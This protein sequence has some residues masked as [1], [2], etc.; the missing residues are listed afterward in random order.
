MNGGKLRQ[1]LLAFGALGL[2]AT[3]FAAGKTGLGPVPHPFLHSEVSIRLPLFAQVVS[4][5]GDR[6]M[7]A[8]IASIRALVTETT[9]MK[10]EEYVTLAGIQEDVSFLNPRHEDNYYTAAAILPWMGHFDSAQHILQRASLARPWDYQPSFYYAF[11]LMHFRRDAAGASAWLR[12]GAEHLPDP[13]ERLIMQNYAAQWIERSDD[14]QLS[15]RVIEMMASQSK[16]P[17]FRDYLLVRAKRLRQLVDLRAAA[18]RYTA[19]GHGTLTRLD[20]LV[21][22]RQIVSIPPDPFGFGYRVDA[23]GMIHLLNDKPK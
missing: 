23:N 8:T 4:A 3:I 14:P 17:V 6:H 10:P 18:V 19:A 7:A 16:V 13:Q 20:D 12:R 15:I 2:G 1:R 9:K 5:A 21:R 11:N 22:T